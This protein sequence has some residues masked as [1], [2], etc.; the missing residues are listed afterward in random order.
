MNDDNVGNVSID[1]DLNYEKYDGLPLNSWV[2]SF[3]MKNNYK[4]GA[5]GIQFVIFKKQFLFD[6]FDA[7]NE[8]KLNSGIALGTSEFYGFSD[9]N[10]I[11]YNN[12]QN[13]LWVRTQNTKLDHIG[14]ELYLDNDNEYVKYKD[15]MLKE[16]KIRVNID[17]NNKILSLVN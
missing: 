11:L 15:Q 5:T 4:V 17:L 13:K 16:Q 7:I 6:F 12:I 10:L 9:S 14:W 3:E 2:P 1:L 8:K